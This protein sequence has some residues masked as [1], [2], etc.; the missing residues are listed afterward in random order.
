MPMYSDEDGKRFAHL[1]AAIM[2]MPANG[3]VNGADNGAVNDTPTGRPD[4][5]LGSMQVDED[6]SRFASSDSCHHDQCR[7][8]K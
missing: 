5:Y 6:G 4:Q 1:E 8:R 7:T 2:S 3:A